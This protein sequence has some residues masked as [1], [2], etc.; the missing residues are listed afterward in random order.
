MLGAV[1][2]F[3]F[4]TA[5]FLPLEMMVD[6]RDPWTFNAQAAIDLKH[7]LQKLQDNCENCL[8]DF[9]EA[10]LSLVS[11]DARLAHDTAENV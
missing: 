4:D 6:P 1:A 9:S 5:R 7:E 3:F 11:A 8:C 10:F 2:C